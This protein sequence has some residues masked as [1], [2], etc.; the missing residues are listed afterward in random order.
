MAQSAAS[1]SKRHLLVGFACVASA[2]LDR[3]L[4]LKG[5]KERKHSPFGEKMVLT[6]HQLGYFRLVDAEQLG[7]FP[8]FELPCLQNQADGVPKLGAREKLI[9]VVKA[10]VGEHVA[11]ADFVFGVFFSGHCSSSDVH[12]SANINRI[13][14]PVG[15]SIESQRDLKH[16]A[17]DALEGLGSR[18]FSPFC[19]SYSADP[20]LLR[21]SGGKLLSCLR[22]SPS[23]ATGLRCSSKRRTII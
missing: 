23:H 22:E 21:T 12:P 4:L 13:H 8:L 14:H 20:T 18:A 6:I 19:A 3:D 16:A 2:Y 11:A 7:D 9:G 15:V 17:S 5:P 1:G 10:Q